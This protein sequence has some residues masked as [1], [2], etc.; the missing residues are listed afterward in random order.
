MDSNFVQDFNE[1]ISTK[2]ETECLFLCEM[3][4]ITRNGRNGHLLCFLD[5]ETEDMP[6]RTRTVS[7]PDKK[8]K[9]ERRSTRRFFWNRNFYHQKRDKKI[10]RLFTEYNHIPGS[11]FSNIAFH[12]RDCLRIP[13]KIRCG[14][15]PWNQNITFGSFRIFYT[16][17][18]VLEWKF[19]LMSTE[20]SSPGRII[21]STGEMN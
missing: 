13:N 14:G 7:C 10:K 15:V 19:T 2:Y 20:Y 9:T 8:V 3:Q 16:F 21:I 4:N 6:I 5:C 18:G 17:H 12:N 11:Y 1:D